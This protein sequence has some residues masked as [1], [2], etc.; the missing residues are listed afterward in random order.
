[1][2]VSPSINLHAGTQQTSV[3]PSG[4]IHHHITK[5]Y[6]PRNGGYDPSPPILNKKYKAILSHYCT[7]N[8]K[9]FPKYETS[10]CD[11]DKYQCRV[12]V[13]KTIGWVKGP[14]AKTIEEA[15]EYAAATLCTRVNITQ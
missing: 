1:M 4:R 13:A 9:P 7:K 14:A 5:M 8:H 3:T 6:I 11:D 10:P 2:V 12:Y 15:E